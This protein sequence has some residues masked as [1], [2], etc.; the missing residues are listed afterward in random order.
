LSAA[1]AAL[2]ALALAACSVGGG[3]KPAPAAQQGVEATTTSTTVAVKAARTMD[4]LGKMLD[5]TV[6]E[7][8]TV[9]ADNVDDTGPSDLEK[10]VSDDGG[11]D[12]SDVLTGDHFVRGYQREWTLDENDQIIA[13]VYQFADATG[14]ADYTR[15]VTEDSEGPADNG[16]MGRFSVPGI[17]GAVG[18]NG[19][20]PNFAAST[21]TFAKGPYSV[22]V[23]VNGA[24][25]AGLESLA[26]SIAEEQYDRL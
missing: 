8:Y 7:G 3:G 5:L 16:A 24:K 26:T 1:F 25:Q 6:P 17:D 2:A 9:L 13:Y 11:D 4:E 12:A 15:R 23:V 18:V 20:D 21:V 14:A 22:Q 10:A 19:S